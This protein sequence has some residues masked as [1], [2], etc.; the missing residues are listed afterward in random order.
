MSCAY[1]DRLDYIADYVRGE[2]PENE[3]EAFEA[4]YLA[5][6]DCFG[7]IRFMEK[8][9]IA[10]HHYGDRIFVPA[11]SFEPA[12]PKIAKTKWPAHLKTWWDD[13]PL[14]QQWK[15]AIPAV[16]TYLLFIGILSAGYYGFKYIGE[17]A[18]KKFSI[19]R[20]QSGGMMPEAAS[21]IV[22]LEHLDW[23]DIED[24]STDAALTAK[25]AE[26]QPIYQ[27][28]HYRQ[29]AERLAAVIREF[30]QSFDAH[31]FLGVCQLQLHQ[32]NEATKNLEAALEITPEHAPAQWYLAQSYLL[33][34]QFDAARQQLAALVKQQDP[35]YSQLAKECLEKIK[36][37]Y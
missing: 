26:I 2:L 18:E 31:L 17:L 16:A 23:L 9:S 25:L 19:H 20:E 27:E 35:R 21:G 10:I 1:Q 37:F 33:Q 32:I 29:A 36:A 12:R 13:L 4:H 30:P 6:S 14:S 7:A 15:D 22:K 11:R 24:S 8:T 5:C 34:H 3:Q 28:R